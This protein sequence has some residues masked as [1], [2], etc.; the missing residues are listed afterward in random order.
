MI[1]DEFYSK[2][3]GIIFT[4]TIAFLNISLNRQQFPI[5]AL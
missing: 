3:G 5:F 2:G 4:Q 1:F